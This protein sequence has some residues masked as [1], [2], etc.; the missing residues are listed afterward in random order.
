MVIDNRRSPII[1][2]FTTLRLAGLRMVNGKYQAARLDPKDFLT[3][4]CIRYIIVN[5]I[6]TVVVCEFLNLKTSQIR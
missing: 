4:F 1:W 5:N 6:M 3:R 2:G